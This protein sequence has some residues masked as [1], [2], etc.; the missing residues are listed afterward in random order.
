[1]LFEKENGLDKL[2]LWRPSPVV[3]SRGDVTPFD[4]HAEFILPNDR[5]R[6]LFLQYLGFQVRNPGVKV[7][8]AIVLQG[9]QRTG[10]SYFGQVMEKVL[11]MHN[12]SRPTNERLHETWT[13]WQEGAQLIVIEELMG[14]GRQEL[15]NKL[16]PMITE[17]TTSVRLVGGHSYSMPNRYNFLM[18][19]NHKGV[20]KIDREDK[21]YC[22]LF[23][24][25]ERR[26]DVYYDNLWL[27][28]EGNLPALADYLATIPLEGFRANGNAP[29]TE[30]RQQAIEMNRSEE[31]VW[32]EEGIQNKDG[33]FACDLAVVEHLLF[34]MPQNLSPRKVTQNSAAEALEN[35]GARQVGRANLKH[36][37]YKRVWALRDIERW[38]KMTEGQ[39]GAAYMTNPARP[40]NLWVNGKSG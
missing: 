21:R 25:A 28:T 7:R 39:R 15:A 1:M 11:G 13:D 16:K 23:S 27:W 34:N 12:V 24:P 38:R 36:F 40:G 30:A 3:P 37:G 2:N 4:A 19:T 5:E 22:I 8:W 17:P 31:A 35:T 9:R 14:Y 10:K 29:E 18:F 32:I 26:E 33:L 20:L 6:H